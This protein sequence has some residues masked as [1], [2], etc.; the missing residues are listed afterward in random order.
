MNSG[1]ASWQK[2][3]E[4]KRNDFSIVMILQEQFFTSEL[5]KVIQDATSMILHY[6]TMYYFR[7]ISSSTFITSDVQSIYIPS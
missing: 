2:E 7:T 5:F 1:R 4:D 3:E 6:R